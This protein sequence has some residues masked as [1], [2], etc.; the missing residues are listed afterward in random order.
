MYI[1]LAKHCYESCGPRRQFE[2]TLAEQPST[3]IGPI[4][5]L[6]LLLL[7]L[8]FL[9]WSAYLMCAYV[10]SHS[11]TRL[12]WHG[13]QKSALSSCIIIIMIWYLFDRYRPSAR[14]CQIFK[15]H[16]WKNILVYGL[17]VSGYFRWVCRFLL[18]S[19]SPL[20][21]CCCDGRCTCMYN[22]KIK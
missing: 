21:W 18:G 11:Y 12:Y 7:L 9:S 6:L 16:M 5:L 22:N 3:K 17:M 1:L 2:V 13:Y 14:I 19:I 8:Q 10:R 4:M 15:E 20:G